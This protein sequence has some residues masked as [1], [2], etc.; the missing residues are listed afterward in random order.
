MHILHSLGRTHSVAWV[1]EK[2]KSNSSRWMKQHEVVDFWWQPGYAAFSVGRSE[3][4][5]VQRYIHAQ[6]EHHREHTFEQEL[7]SLCGTDPADPS[8]LQEFLAHEPRGGGTP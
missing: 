5:H 2:V 6:R 1:M 3:L 8:A 7:R 4:E